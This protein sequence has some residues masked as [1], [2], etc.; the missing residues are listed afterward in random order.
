MV[1]RQ[2]LGTA[3]P[4]GKPYWGNQPLAAGTP[5]FSAART[6]RADSH[7]QSGQQGEQKRGGMRLILSGAELERRVNTAGWRPCKAAK[8]SWERH[9]IIFFITPAI[10]ACLS[11]DY[12]ISLRVNVP[13]RLLCE[14]VSL[15][16]VKADKDQNPC[17]SNN[18]S[19][20]EK[21]FSHQYWHE[22]PFLF[23]GVHHLETN[24]LSRYVYTEASNNI[25]R[26]VP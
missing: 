6:M 13:L 4:G 22:T 23:I 10:C 11:S 14:I 8:F 5:E 15:D 2:W 20:E 21:V 7:H 9:N 24:I 26:I 12:D 17:P 1:S 25:F 3:L 18:L 16:T 19:S